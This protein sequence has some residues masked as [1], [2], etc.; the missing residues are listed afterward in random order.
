MRC[1]HKLFTKEGLI[2]NIGSYLL[3]ITFIFFM[4]SAIIFYKCGYQIIE[5][6]ITTILDLKKKR[7]TAKINIFDTIKK[8]RKSIK[9]CKKEK[10]IINKIQKRKKVY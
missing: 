4:I 10:K 7:S 8:Q 6:Y 2:T 9:I 3:I 5:D 1:T